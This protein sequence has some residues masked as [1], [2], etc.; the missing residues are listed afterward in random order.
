MLLRFSNYFFLLLILALCSAF[1][2][3][4]NTYNYKVPSKRFVLHDTLR[5][6]SGITYIDSSTI[7]CIQDENGIVFMYDLKQN[8]IIRQFTF[9][10]DGDYEGICRVNQNL[11]ILRSDGMLYE[12]S[13]YQNKK[14]TV[15]SWYTSVPAQNNEG[16]CYDKK[17]NRLLIGCKG[18][19]NKGAEY[20]DIRQVY[21]FNLATKQLNSKAVYTFSV[22]EI[23]AFAKNHQLH[24]HSKTTKN[25]KDTGPVIRFNTSEIAIHPISGDVYILS[26]T[27]HALFIFNEAGTLQHIEQLDPVLFN[28][29]E[30]ITFFPNGDMIISNEAQAKKPTLLKFD[31]SN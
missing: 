24:F 11:Y 15:K 26:A 20:K 16:L 14:P 8:K 18:K 31:Y 12:V 29:P 9:N 25:G 7:A 23:K 13:N 10:I 19:I 22:S 17:H 1:N 21:E 5:E 30:G 4:V 2:F 6:V 27:D 3:F 28:K